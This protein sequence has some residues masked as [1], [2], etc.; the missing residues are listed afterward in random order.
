[1]F[2]LIFIRQA[3][4]V[5]CVV[6][7][8]KALFWLL[9]VLDKICQDNRYGWRVGVGLFLLWNNWGKIHCMYSLRQRYILVQFI[10]WTNWYFTFFR[11]FEYQAIYDFFN[12]P[13]M[14]N[15]LRYHT[16]NDISPSRMNTN[17]YI[18]E[19][20]NCS[21]QVSDKRHTCCSNYN[22]SISSSVYPT[23]CPSVNLSG[24]MSVSSGRFLGI[25]LL[26]L[27]ENQLNFTQL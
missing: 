17:R 1:M 9:I 19:I 15:V 27:K 12:T 10:N 2:T 6:P 3:L 23:V 5:D 25:T 26:L 22:L 21:K 4:I 7:T 11:L 16:H 20:Q 13:Y 24:H 8:E 14:W 18:H